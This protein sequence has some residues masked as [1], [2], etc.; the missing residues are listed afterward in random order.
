[1]NFILW[2]DSYRILLKIHGVDLE[3]ESYKNPI[4]IDTFD[5]S[6]IQIMGFRKVD[7]KRIKRKGEVNEAGPSLTVE[8]SQDLNYGQIELAQPYFK[9]DQDQLKTLVDHMIINLLALGNSG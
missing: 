9:L 4:Q 1:M 5:G 2:Y 6:S 3:G 7:G 8:T